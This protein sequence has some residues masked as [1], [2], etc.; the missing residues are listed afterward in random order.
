MLYR[1][2]PKLCHPTRGQEINLRRL[3]GNRNVRV[4]TLPGKS[5]T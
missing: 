5:R 4:R 2:F 1:Y 3:K